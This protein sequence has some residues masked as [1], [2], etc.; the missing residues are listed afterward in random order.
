MYMFRRNEPI[1]RQELVIHLNLILPVSAEKQ[2]VPMALV[3]PLRLRVKLG[4]D[5]V[6]QRRRQVLYGGLGSRMPRCWL[7]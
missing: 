6:E 2:R 5:V 1:Q 7:N 3:V 4:N